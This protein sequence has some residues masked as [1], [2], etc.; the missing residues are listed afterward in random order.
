MQWLSATAIAA[1]AAIATSP[2]A[3]VAAALC[4]RE[5]HRLRHQRSSRLVPAAAVL[6]SA[7]AV[8][9]KHPILVSGHLW[10]MRTH[11]ATAIIHVGIA[12]PITSS[13]ATSCRYVSGDV[14]LLA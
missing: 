12:T 1:I 14:Q 8:R 10:S 9:F 13:F 11:G 3:I 7:L 5:L 2:T 4:G 6:L